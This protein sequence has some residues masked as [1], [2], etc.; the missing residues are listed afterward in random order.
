MEKVHAEKG[1]TVKGFPFGDHGT[2]CGRLWVC[3]TVK[4]TVQACVKS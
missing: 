4:A 2:A 3:F 1:K